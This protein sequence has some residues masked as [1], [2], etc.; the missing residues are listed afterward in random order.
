[1]RNKNSRQDN[2]ENV[3]EEIIKEMIQGDFS[4]QRRQMFSLKR[5]TEWIKSD[6]HKAHN[7]EVSEH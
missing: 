3:E 4:D 1:M 2:R 6:I 7:H 5:P